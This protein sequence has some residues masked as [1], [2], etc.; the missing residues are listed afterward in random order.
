[1]VVERVPCVVLENFVCGRGAGSVRGT[2]I[3]SVW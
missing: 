3:V 1:V 2:E